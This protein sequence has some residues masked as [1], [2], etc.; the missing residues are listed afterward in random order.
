MAINAKK[1]RK[2]GIRLEEHAAHVRSIERASE[3]N[4]CFVEIG[5]RTGTGTAAIIDTLR[6]LGQTRE[7]VSID[8]TMDRLALKK[9]IKGSLQDHI[10]IRKRSDEANPPRKIAWLFVDGCHCFHCVREDLDRYGDRIVPGGILVMHDTTHGRTGNK[11]YHVQKFCYRLKA[12]TIYGVHLAQ[13][14]SVVLTREFK[15]IEEVLP[16]K[17]LA[18]YQREG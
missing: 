9:V 7:I 14:S 16:I 1:V 15:L 2:A 6:L 8:P 3:V 13:I 5:V 18:V 4:G 10:L 12:K 17:G 11:F